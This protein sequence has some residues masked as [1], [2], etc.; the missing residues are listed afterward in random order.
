MFSEMAEVQYCLKIID[1]RP[2]ILISHTDH[3][4][5]MAKK[6]K[7]KTKQNDRRKN[8]QVAHVSSL[9]SKWDKSNF[10]ESSCVQTSSINDGGNDNNNDYNNR[11]DLMTTIIIFI[12]III[13]IT[14]TII[15]IIIITTSA[16]RQKCV[17]SGYLVAGSYKILN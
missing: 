2:F 11:Y 8:S 17:F 9:Q 4:D 1:N 16:I 13:V 15:I 5:Y 14:F 12:I 6:K 7:N 10:S 3:T